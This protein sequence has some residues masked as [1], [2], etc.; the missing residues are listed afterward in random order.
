MTASARRSMGGNGRTTRRRLEMSDDFTYPRRMHT[1]PMTADT[2]LQLILPGKRTELVRGRLVVRE[3]VGAYRGS[4]AM[5]IAYVIMKFAEPRGLGRVFAAETGFVLA[6]NPDTVRAPDVAFV[7]TERLPDPIP[8]GF[9]E[10]VPDL[11]VEVVSPGDRSGEVEEKVTAWLTAGVALVWVVDPQRRSACVHRA[12]GGV[13]DVGDA[14]VLAGE[15][16]LPGLEV[17]LATVF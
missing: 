16:V 7:R 11:A 6:T 2:L 14:G 9:A 13:S 5:R 4:V 15:E 10:F 8:A 17:E 3:P 1:A 12:D